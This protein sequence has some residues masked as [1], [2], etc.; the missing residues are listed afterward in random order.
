MTIIEDSDFPIRPLTLNIQGLSPL[1][2]F[3]GQGSQGLEVVVLSSQSKPDV[4]ILQKAFAVQLVQ[5]KCPQM[6]LP[7]W[8]VR[9]R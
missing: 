8:T 9:A 7:F 5:Q 1:G 2:L 6:V 4:G 3:L